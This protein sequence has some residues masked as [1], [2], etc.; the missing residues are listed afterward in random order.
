[1]S[2]N[3]I[4]ASQSPQRLA[5]L[6]QIGYRPEKI[7]PA[8]ID[9]TPM[10]GEKPT[11]YVKRM[12]LEKALHVAEKHPQEVVLASDTV[13]VVGTMIVQKSKSDE[14]QEKVMKMLSGRT[15]RVLT[16]VCVV[17]KKGKAA[18]R[19]NTTK[20]KMKRLSLQEITEYVAS[21]EWKGCS[22][23]KIEGLLGGFV[24]QMIGS[25]SGVVGLPLFESRNL[26][27][28]AGVL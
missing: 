18:V 21:G 12:A 28:G 14:E 6:E 26:L 2:K 24:A 1:M 4:L 8:D 25:Y 13:I 9:E 22:G 17:D 11:Q 16:A 27:M 15:H 7:E 23:Y 20:I 10:K 5:L 3:F 19:L